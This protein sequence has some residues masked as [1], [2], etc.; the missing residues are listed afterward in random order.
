MVPLTHHITSTSKFLKAV[1]HKFYLVFLEYLELSVKPLQRWIRNPIKQL[2]C[3]TGFHV[4]IN[5]DFNRNLEIFKNQVDI[6]ANIW[7][8]V[9]INIHTWQELTQRG[10]S[11]RKW[12]SRDHMLQLISYLGRTKREEVSFVPMSTP[13]NRK[14]N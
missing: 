8:L 10:S 6:L 2:R 3:L 5:F 4:N 14:T 11:K 13:I 7:R 9:W 12:V 1:C